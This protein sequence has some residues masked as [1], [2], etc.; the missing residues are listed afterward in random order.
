MV[1]G[2]R[3]KFI[4]P[5]SEKLEQALARQY[6]P[7]EEQ[8]GKEVE[9]D[10]VKGPAN[11]RGS[12]IFTLE[13]AK[14][15]FPDEGASIRK[16]IYDSPTKDGETVV[17]MYRGDND[18][19]IETASDHRC[20]ISARILCN[21]DFSFARIYLCSRNLSDA[22]FGINNAAMLLFAFTTATLGTLEFHSS[23]VSND[24]RA[25]MFLG[26]SG[27]GKSTHSRMWLQY[28]TGSELMNDDNPIVRIMPDGNITVYGSPWSGKTPCYRNISMPLGALVKINQWPGNRIRKME[29]LEAYATL[30]SSVSGFKSDNLDDSSDERNAD[31]LN[32]SLD[33]LLSKVSCYHLDCLPDEGA[34]VLC[35]ETIKV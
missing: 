17:K 31:G 27:A 11:E 5:E 33:K 8:D 3:F 34:A 23:V 28:T 19:L 25:Y 21:N 16:C 14:E 29:T 6:E 24:G 18:V 35:S 2:H 10:C 26:H 13:L 20:P 4:L 1:A 12:L 9:G 30:L 32:D 7:F 15:D 22:V